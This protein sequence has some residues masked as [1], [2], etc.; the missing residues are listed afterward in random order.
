MQPT[1]EI[2]GD[3]WKLA[4][5]EADI[6]WCKKQIWEL[7]SY[8]VPNDHAHCSICWWSIV[9]PANPEIGIAYCSSETKW[10]CQECFH[11]FINQGIAS[12]PIDTGS[13]L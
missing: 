12:G 11:K 2:H 3:S 6:D 4:D 5:I 8:Q 7:K 9:I 13:S 1:V 10:I